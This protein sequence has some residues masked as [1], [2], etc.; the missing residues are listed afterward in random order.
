[1]RQQTLSRRRPPEPKVDS[2]KVCRKCP[3][4]HISNVGVVFFRTISVNCHR[5][6]EVRLVTYISTQRF[7]FSRSYLGQSPFPTNHPII[8]VK[9]CWRVLVLHLSS[10][11]RFGRFTLLSLMNIDVFPRERKGSNFAFRFTDG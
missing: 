1:M 5:V 3:D 11:R 2:Q 10:V 8:D 9:N 6:V 4:F 7:C